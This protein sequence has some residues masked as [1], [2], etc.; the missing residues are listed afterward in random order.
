[1][2]SVIPVGPAGVSRMPE[3]SLDRPGTAVS[4]GA[5]G[6]RG[7]RTGEEWRLFG[8]RE[9]DARRVSGSQVGVQLAAQHQ[10]PAMDACLDCLKAKAGDLRDLL[11]V[12]LLEVAQD[13]DRPVLVRQ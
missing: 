6:Q 3:G 8:I 13:D 5:T 2:V 4:S 7:G 12:D 1:M 10:A 9:C 11:V